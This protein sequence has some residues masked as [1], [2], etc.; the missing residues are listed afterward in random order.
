MKKVTNDLI[1]EVLKQMQTDIA[2]LKHGQQELRDSFI[3]V[4]EDIH[5]LSGRVLSLEKAQNNVELRLARI[6]KRFDL[7]EA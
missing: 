3:I 5:S 7:V 2:H 6:E 4:R 1:Y